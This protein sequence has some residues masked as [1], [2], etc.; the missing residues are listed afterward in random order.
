MELK[1]V[2]G[3]SHWLRNFVLA[4]L[5]I[6]LIAA[7]LIG[8]AFSSPTA[9]TAATHR[10]GSGS[11]HCSAEVLTPSQV[12]IRKVGNYCFLKITGNTTVTLPSYVSSVDI[13]AT[14]GGGG[15]GK[16]GGQ[17]GSGGETRYQNNMSVNP[18]VSLTFSIGSGGAGGKFSSSS[19]ALGGVQTTISVPG[20]ETMKAM[21]GVGGWGWGTQSRSS[22]NNP[23]TGGSGGT[24]VVGGHGGANPTSGECTFQNPSTGGDAG[25]FSI[26]GVSLWGAGGGGGGWGATNGSKVVWGG[27]NG[28]AS[29]GGFGAIAN[30]ESSGN[31][32][33]TSG[34]PGSLNTG[35]G[36]GG[37]QACDR[38]G[39][40][41]GSTQR[42][43][44]GD[45]GSGVA[46]L[47]F[48]M[49]NL[50]SVTAADG[51][52]NSSG[53]LMRIQPKLKLGDTSLT[54][55]NVTVTADKGTVDGTTTIRSSN[56][57]VQFTDLKYFDSNAQPNDVRKLYFEAPGFGSFTMEFRIKVVA[58][59]LE[60][61]SGSSEGKFFVNEFLDTSSSAK[62]NTTYL[63]ERLASQDVT[64]AV[65]GFIAVT[66]GFTST[67]TRD[68]T[69]KAGSYINV[70]A[71][72]QI[73]TAGGDIVLWADSDN[74]SGGYVR[75]LKDATL[76]TTNQICGT[77]VS[78]GGDIVIGG[79]SADSN[80][81]LRPG[82]T[83]K[84]SGYSEAANTADTTGVQLGTMQA[85]GGG[86]KL[87]SSGGNI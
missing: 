66:S 8:A 68:L 36:G 49:Q 15:G 28:G 34:Y 5:G 85:G 86:V 69:L 39:G 50:T 54:N 16:D 22:N 53:Q 47:A 29:G 73:R 21:G 7:V 45:G 20:S 9:A 43:N 3:A 55:V 84:G 14:G 19:F 79:G 61:T 30:N 63:T 37:G 70:A 41:N 4:T 23:Q 25:T 13:G 27:A 78:G 77:S 83:A 60:I 57:V 12:Q 52:L 71:S 72:Q 48:S 33:A 46:Y 1:L 64:L 6:G 44:G 2:R 75:L 82:G 87:F 10:S 17:G 80:N 74:V 11:G 62:L 67:S 31:N 18:G 26:G 38:P 58:V 35:G 56:G 59:N 81:P 51:V 40:T 76:C 65:P 42:T 24:Q 32:W